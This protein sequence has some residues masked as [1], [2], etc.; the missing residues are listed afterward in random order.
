MPELHEAL[1]LVIG[2]WTE[3][4]GVDDTERGR[5][6]GDPERQGEDGNRREAGRP[7][8]ATQGWANLGD[9]RHQDPIGKGMTAVRVKFDM[10]FSQ[11]V[12]VR[13]TRVTSP[14]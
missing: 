9:E 2:Q 6:A 12:T 11:K 4:D 10:R 7:R 8:E 5:R 14:V 13:C 3:Q 1:W